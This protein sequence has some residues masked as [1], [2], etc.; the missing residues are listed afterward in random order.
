M[1]PKKKMGEYTYME[2]DNRRAKGVSK[3]KAG[4]G[5]SDLEKKMSKLAK[6]DK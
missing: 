6:Q 2:E 1:V 5:E 3:S 4:Q